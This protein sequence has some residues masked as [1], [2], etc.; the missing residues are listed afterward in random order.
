MPYCQGM[1]Y[2]AGLILLKAE[3]DKTA[4]SFFCRVIDTLFLPV[5]VDNFSGMQLK[6]Y[7]LERLMAIFHPDLSE[8]L[9]REM[10]SPECY[11]VGWVIT[12][13]SSAYQYTQKSFLIDWFWERFVLW[14]WA[15]FYRLTLWLLQIHRVHLE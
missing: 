14:G 6:L 7:L 3:D 8:H 10:I 11:A 4:Y 9:K 1:N 12:A 2:V 15:E 13:F 5:F